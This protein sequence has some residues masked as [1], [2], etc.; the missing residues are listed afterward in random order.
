MGFLMTSR[1]FEA[2]RNRQRKR[3]F[4]FFRMTLFRESTN[5]QIRSPG[6]SL[7]PSRQN[8]MNLLMQLFDYSGRSEA[9]FHQGKGVNKGE[10][11]L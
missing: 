7:P 4:F 1:S 5:R 10:E 11:E 3:Q 8:G 9:N 6:D 2:L